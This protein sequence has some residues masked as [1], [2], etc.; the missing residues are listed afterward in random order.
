[1]KSESE[2]ETATHP[3][4]LARCGRGARLRAAPG[5]MGPL[6]AAGSCTPVQSEADALSVASGSWCRKQQP[7]EC[8]DCYIRRPGRDLCGRLSDCARSRYRPV[9]ECALQPRV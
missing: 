3:R 5:A 8:S 4:Q 1:M 7:F 6:K 2:P 9:V